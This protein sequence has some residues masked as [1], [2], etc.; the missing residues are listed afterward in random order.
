ME[1]YECEGVGRMIGTIEQ[2]IKDMKNGV[3]DFREKV[4]L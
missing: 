2:M 4:V 3:Y 1:L